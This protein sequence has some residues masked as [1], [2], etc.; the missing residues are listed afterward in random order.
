MVM[1]GAVH[2]ARSGIVVQPDRVDGG[3]P[4]ETGLI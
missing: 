2:L 3:R 4:N 1:L